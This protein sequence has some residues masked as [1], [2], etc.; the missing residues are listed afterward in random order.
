MKEVYVGVHDVEEVTL[1][2]VDGSRNEILDF[3]VVRIG[4][5]VVLDLE[6]SSSYSCSAPSDSSSIDTRRTI[7]D[8]ASSKDT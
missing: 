3:V 4:Y 2:V 7:V 6:E 8:S 1:D 5:V